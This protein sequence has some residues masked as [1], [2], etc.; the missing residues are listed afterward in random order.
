VLVK[1]E[2]LAREKLEALKLLLD[3]TNQVGLQVTIHYAQL[4]STLFYF[5][6]V[7]IVNYIVLFVILLFS[8]I[9]FIILLFFL[10]FTPSNNTLYYLLC[11]S[12][13][14][15]RVSATRVSTQFHPLRNLT[16]AT[17]RRASI[18]RVRKLR[19]V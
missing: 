18:P 5:T 10:Q 1:E 17:A 13:S 12:Y 11:Y 9:F 8:F 7:D 4:Y 6:D 19:K 15:S 16:R 3:S 2:V 14:H